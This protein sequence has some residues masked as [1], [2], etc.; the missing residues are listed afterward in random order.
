MDQLEIARINLGSVILSEEEL[1]KFYALELKAKNKSI[2][3]WPV[4]IRWI[5]NNY[6]DRKTH[7][8]LNNEFRNI[9]AEEARKQ[10][11]NL[12]EQ[13]MVLEEARQKYINLFNHI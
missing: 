8:L 9:T 4:G 2:N 3:I 1:A 6:V 12:S 13:L 11:I 7:D 10:Y 5:L